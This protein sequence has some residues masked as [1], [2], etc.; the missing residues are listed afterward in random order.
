MRVFLTGATGFIGGHVLDHLLAAGHEVTCLV[1]PGRSARR[2]LA[3]PRAGA[4]AIAGEMTRDGPWTAALA[5]HDVLVNTTGIIR[6]SRRGD[7]ARIHQEAPIAL[8]DRATAAGIRRIVQVSA[9]GADDGATSAFHLTKRAADRHLAAIGVD[10]VVLRPSIVYGPGDHS[11]AMFAG[12][13]AQPAVLVPGA[14]EPRVQPIHVHDLARAVVL[15]IEPR[16]DERASIDAGGPEPIAFA[17]LLRVLARW[18]GRPRGPLQVGVPWPIMALVARVTDV[19]G[20]GPISREELSMLRRGNTCDTAAFAARFA[21][22]PEGVSSRLGREPATAPQVLHARLAPWKVPIRLMVA[23]I[24]IA[25]SIVSAFLYPVAESLALLARTGI[26]GPIALPILYGTCALEL[27]IGLATA[28]GWRVR[29]MAAIQLALMASF[30]AILTLATPEMWIH[31]FGP[32]T[33]NIPLVAATIA[34]IALED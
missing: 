20:A 26:E 5:D 17:D 19:L 14:G 11:M 9:L 3:S 25:T 8:F 6:E 21:F 4:T 31:P 7:F 12:M 30:T 27:A 15:A 16:A 13:A 10:H 2:F 33:K 18:L 24:W 34:M 23:S 28:L 22:V 32:L 1:R 29:T